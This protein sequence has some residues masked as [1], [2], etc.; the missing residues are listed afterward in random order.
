M[1]R[2]TTGTIV[3]SV[4]LALAVVLG[5]AG[6]GG[7]GVGQQRELA[8]ARSTPPATSTATSTSTST[9]TSTSTSTAQKPKGARPARGPLKV[10]IYGDSLA[11]ESSQ[12]F[13]DALTAKGRAVVRMGVFG[14]TAICD[15]L[16]R[17]QTDAR[18]W[19]PQAV[20]V[21]FSGDTFTACMH[22]SKGEPL[23]P[24][25][26]DARYAQDAQRV[27]AIFS[28]IA[29]RL[30]FVNYPISRGEDPS[31]SAEWNRLNE[32]YAALVMRSPRTELVD[33]AGAVE[34]HGR[35]ADTLPCLMDEP[36]NGPAGAGRQ[37]ENLVRAPDGVHFCPNGPSA[38]NGV[39][40]PCSVWSSG[41]FRYGVAMAAPVITDFGV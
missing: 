26:R 7:S 28:S 8:G 33:A 16:T 34:D 15:W 12:A 5:I 18:T 13:V 40:V 9:A 6:C 31:P 27:V 39:T 36:C 29:E 3:P 25:A 4:A 17:M 19:H 20:V 23:S 38:I 41:A 35:Y 21:E 30:Y 2:R 32:M 37:P 10:A 24:A 11:W 1:T 14:G 22:T